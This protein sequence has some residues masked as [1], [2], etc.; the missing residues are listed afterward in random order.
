MKD[1]KLLSLEDKTKF[2]KS[3]RNIIKAI[4]L[5]MEEYKD[6]RDDIKLL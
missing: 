4:R 5:E 2:Y 6:I 3:I 1:K